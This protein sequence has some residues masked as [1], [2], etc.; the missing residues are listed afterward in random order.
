ML[1]AYEKGTRSFDGRPGPHYW[2]NR[3]SYQMRV[4]LVPKKRRVEGS[5][6]ISYYNQSPD[7]LRLLRFKLAADRYRKGSLRDDD[8]NPNDVGEGVRIEQLTLNDKAVAEQERIRRRTF[9]DVDLRKKPLLPRDSLRIYVRW[10]YTLPADKNAARECVCDPTTFF[11]PYWYPQIAVYDDIRGWASTPYSG[12]QE[13][14]HDFAD[15]DVTLIV[16]KGF[17]VWATGEWKNAADLLQAPYLERFLLAHRVDTVV[18]IFTEEELRRGGVFRPQ[19][20]HVFR[21]QATQVPDFTFAASD[22]YNW[23]A[24][25]VVV[26]ST[27]GRRTFVSAAYHSRSADFYRVARI[28]ADGIRL[29]SF[30]LPG[31]PFPYPCMTIFNGNDGMEYPMMVNDYSVAPGDPTN[32][33]VHE[34]AHTYFPFLMGI[35]EQEYAWMDE[36]WASFFDFFLADSLTGR[37]HNLR[38][39]AA[40][41]GNDFDVPPMVRSSFLRSPAYSVASYSRPQAAYTVLLDQLGYEVF[42]RCMVEY[43][44]RW[45]GKHPTPYDFF[46]TWN[47]TSGQNLNWF[48]RPWFFEWG[49]PD[50]GVRDVQRDSSAECDVIVIERLGNLPIPIH[51]Q[52]N[53]TDK[54]SEIVHLKADIWKNGE[55]RYAVSCAPG[56]S[57]SH[58]ELGNRLIPDRNRTNNSWKRN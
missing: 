7:T 20:P 31:Y 41:A 30:W 19:N 28:A 39:Y 53:Y 55:Q 32:L 16:P 3:A 29:M 5:A 11:V 50:V 26:D 15:Y 27:T 10:S 38:G 1:R 47:E 8:V 58:I 6:I 36:G 2:Q 33:T 24:T 23:D 35:N 12:Q 34:V 46:F 4:K 42:H 37:K 17:M 21:Y 43:M 18:R 45:K 22:H 54:T 57:V 25:S 40:V 14:Y 56:K 13:F 48:W 51:L 52:I 9:L 44:N 49:Y